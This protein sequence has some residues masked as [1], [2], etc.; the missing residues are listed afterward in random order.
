M[1]AEILAES[2]DQKKTAM[3]MEKKR[4]AVLV[5]AVASPGGVIASAIS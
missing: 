4:P 3:L 1:D 5:Q 2:G